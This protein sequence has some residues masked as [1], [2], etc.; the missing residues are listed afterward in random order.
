M[1][2][3]VAAS[4]TRSRILALTCVATLA[5]T[6]TIA[7]DSVDD[8][9]ALPELESAEFRGAEW[10]PLHL[11]AEIE[12]VANTELK[13]SPS[14]SLNF[15]CIEGL[16][17]TSQYTLAYPICIPPLPGYCADTY[18]LVQLC[19]DGELQTTSNELVSHNCDYSYSGSA[20]SWGPELPK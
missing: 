8:P 18:E 10:S 11:A 7:C 1:V 2:L 16:A 14:Y 12:A 5:T 3:A 15:D 13:L 19:V 20:C 17:I 9:E 6:A 4:M